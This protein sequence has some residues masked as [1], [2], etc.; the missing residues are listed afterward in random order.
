MMKVHRKLVLSTVAVGLT[1]V[2]LA[3]AV[4]A[5]ASPRDHGSGPSSAKG[6]NHGKRDGHG[7]TIY[8]SVLAASSPTDPQFHGV[9]AGGAPWALRDGSVRLQANGELD[10]SVHGLVLTATGTPGPVT[11]IAASLLCG[12]DAQ[13]GAAAT[14]ATAPLS[15]K[16]DASF[17]ASITVPATCLA[18][19]VVINPNGNTA[20][21]IAA[22]GWKS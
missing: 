20:A 11:S 3:F 2:S 16:G 9:A 17:R 8:R 14:T 15:V 22:A 21:Y 1:A 19:I 5:G 12:A 18:P 6:D 13:T 7:H 4:T 10:V